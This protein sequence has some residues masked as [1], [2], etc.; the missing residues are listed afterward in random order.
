MVLDVKPIMD[1]N[2]IKHRLIGHFLERIHMLE[3][4]SIIVNRNDLITKNNVSR[5]LTCCDNCL[6]VRS[7]LTCETNSGIC[8]LCYE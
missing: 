4:G 8:K 6:W 5:I 3:K 1:H 2:F 7:P